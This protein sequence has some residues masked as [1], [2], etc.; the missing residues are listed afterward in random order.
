MPKIKQTASQHLRNLVNEFGSEIFS[1]D[2]QILYCKL[3]ETRVASEKRFTVQQHVT[4][5]KHKRVIALDHLKK[6][7][8]LQVKPL[9]TEGS[10]K[11]SLD[12]CEAL[13]SANIPLGKLINSKFRSFLETYTNK[14]IPNE[15]T[16]RKNYVKICYEKTLERIRVAVIGQKVWV[17]IDETTDVDGRHIANVVI[18][19]LKIDSNSRIFLLN[20]E[21][22][23]K[24]NH[25]TICKLFDKSM[26]L[27]WPNGV[28]HDD[29]LLFLTDGAPYMIKAGN[30]MKCLYTKMLH[31]T[32]VA[33]GFHRVAEEIRSH[34]PIVDLL[35][36]NVKKVFLKSSLR[37]EKFKT[38]APTL[39]LPPR[40]ILTRWGTWLNAVNYYCD[41]FDI[42]QNIVMNLDEDGSNCVKIA[43]DC[44][45]NTSVRND[46][47]YIKS[48]FGFL[49]STILKLEQRG[50]T[51]N[52]YLKLITAADESLNSNSGIL[53]KVIYSKFRN[54]IDKNT[55]LHV[56]NNIANVLSGVSSD[57]E[58]LDY[59]I[60]QSDLCHFIYA[61]ITSVDVERSFS[62]HKNVLANNR[63]SFLFENLRMIFTVYC[64]NAED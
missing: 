46:L 29:V 49:P 31:V 44:F 42:L 62:M 35:I 30:G 17:S 1:T 55:G 6:Q 2:G 36:S 14:V 33:H 63:R 15:S 59:E 54:V 40:P 12:L 32:C 64:N 39:S 20:S 52:N 18:G 48:N 58:T 4:R 60:N 28:Q 61:A 11:F 8:L 19:T 56:L 51:L 43:K 53:A 22:L 24:L 13:I 34:Y 16:L 9:L 57:L 27:L 50:E 7:R 45:S 37:I 38:L 3:C 26:H 47:S 21:Q 41:N 23:D 10:C 5:E 25:S